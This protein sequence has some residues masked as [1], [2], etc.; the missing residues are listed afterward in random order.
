[1][2]VEYVIMDKEQN[3]A[4]KEAIEEYRAASRARIAKTSQANSNSI[5]GVLPR[6][7]I[8]NYFVQFR[9]VLLSEFIMFLCSQLFFYGYVYLALIVAV[10]FSFLLCRSQTILY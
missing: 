7:Q 10:L 8:S 2:Q 9:K 1:M 6:R 4:Y 3:D 5:V